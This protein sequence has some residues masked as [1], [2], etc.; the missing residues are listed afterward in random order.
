MTHL[1]ERINVPGVQPFRL[2]ILG[3]HALARAPHIHRILK[4][5]LANIDQALALESL[6]LDLAAGVERVEVCFR[7]LLLL[8][9]VGSGVF[10]GV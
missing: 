10:T 3:T 9:P 2:F 7:I 8:E 5:R 4:L 6:A 1:F